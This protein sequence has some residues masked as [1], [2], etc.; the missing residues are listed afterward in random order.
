MLNV[1]RWFCGG[2]G[3]VLAALTLGVSVLAVMS[4]GFGPF[5]FRLI[6]PFGLLPALFGGFAAWFAWQTNPAMSEPKDRQNRTIRLM[7]LG[8]V[9][10]MMFAFFAANLM[11]KPQ[12]EGDG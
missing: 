4:V 5:F 8:L 11:L 7:A 1:A 10:L 12:L 2:A 3:V 9:A 6:V